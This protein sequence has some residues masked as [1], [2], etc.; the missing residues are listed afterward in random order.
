MEDGSNISDPIPRFYEEVAVM[1]Q[2]EEDS[3]KYNDFRN[4]CK[5]LIA[6]PEKITVENLLESINEDSAYNAIIFVEELF[7][8]LGEGKNELIVND[9]TIS[10]QRIVHE[11]SDLRHS[12][13]N[14][15]GR[16]DYS[17]YVYK[18]TDKAG[19]EHS[20]NGHKW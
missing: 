16:G 5:K 8:E 7:N 2:E 17:Y 15:I 12:N 19:I 6:N 4:K 14:K 11:A 18:W 20:K 9:I 1:K 10:R 13:P 3:R